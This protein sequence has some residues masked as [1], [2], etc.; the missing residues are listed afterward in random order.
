MIRK[1]ATKHEP[2][3]ARQAAGQAAESDMAFYLKRAFGDS[4]NVHV[5][6]DFRFEHN[7]ENAQMDHLIL[8]RFGMMVVES[9]SVSTSVKINER[10]EW[11]R[12]WDE[13]WSGMPSPIQ[14]AKVQLELLWSLLDDTGDNLLGKMLGVVQR[15]FGA[16]KYD[17]FAAISN[18]GIVERASSADYP[19]VCKADQVC[20]MAWNKICEYRAQ[21]SAAGLVATAYNPLNWGKWD[22]RAIFEF[23]DS[24][25]GKVSDFLLSLHKEPLY[26]APENVPQ[27][28]E[29]AK[30]TSNVLILPDNLPPNPTEASSA[31][32]ASCEARL[33]E[34]VMQYC[35]ENPKRF[36]GHMYC[37]RC[38]KNH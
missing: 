23:N 1:D 30:V 32:C 33:S 5:F 7:G 11:S 28:A 12:L 18:R 25:F 2:E 31:V 19:N 9:K 37:M 26:A 29:D 6:N 13:K 36:S 22:K 34:R 17:V 24:D 16:Y 14:Q 3:N 27:I 35:R 8:H 38:Q 20:D 15:R 4:K 21:A 10:G